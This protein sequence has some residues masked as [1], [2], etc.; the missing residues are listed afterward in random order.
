[1]NY[2]WQPGAAQLPEQSDPNT[3]WLR[4]MLA[5][6]RS[7]YPSKRLP[8]LGSGSRKRLQRVT[9]KGFKSALHVVP[10][11]VEAGLFY[12]LRQ[13]D[14]V[15]GTTTS[16]SASCLSATSQPTRSQAGWVLSDAGDGDYFLTTA[17]GNQTMTAGSS[18]AMS[19]TLQ[20]LTGDYTQRWMIQDVGDGRRQLINRANN[21]ALTW[22]PASCVN[23]SGDLTSELSKWTLTAH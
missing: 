14:Q 17:D 4:S 5:Q 18:D 2:Y 9:I 23:V 13:G 10:N 11:T 15:L 22:S 1:M 19:V 16:G 20:A 8:M 6:T 3:Q 12:T 7:E 21:E